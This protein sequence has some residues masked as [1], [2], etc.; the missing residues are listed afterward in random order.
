MSICGGTSDI[1]PIGYVGQSTLVTSRRL[2]R[3]SSFIVRLSVWIDVRLQRLRQTKRVDDSPQ[4]CAID[5]PDDADH[6][7]SA[8]HFHFR[9]VADVRAAA[10]AKRHAAAPCRTASRPTLGEDGLASPSVLL[11][12]GGCSTA[13]AR[14]SV[15]YFE[16]NSIGSTPAAAASSSMKRLHG[17]RRRRPVRIAKMRPG[18]RRGRRR[19]SGMT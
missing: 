17:K 3:T 8:V 6:S 5:E 2:N 4:S 14:S 1:R 9:D 18:Q 7:A 12:G 15:R 16:R 13:F 11:R 10:D 19:R